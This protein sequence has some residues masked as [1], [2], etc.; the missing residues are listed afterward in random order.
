MDNFLNRYHLPNLNKDKVGNL[1]RP[2]ITIEIEAVI[3]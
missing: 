2:K 1:N 3:P